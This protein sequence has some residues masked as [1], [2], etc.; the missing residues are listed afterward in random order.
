[1]LVKQLQLCQSTPD[2]AKTHQLIIQN[3]GLAVHFC[4]VLQHIH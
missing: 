2:A 1:M 3:F 4:N